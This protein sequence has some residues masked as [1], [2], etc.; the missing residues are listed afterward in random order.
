VYYSGLK[1]QQLL[2]AALSSATGNTATAIYN[3]GKS[4][5]YGF[6]VDGSVRF[7]SFFRVDGS[8]TYVNSELVRFDVPTVIP[9]FDVI[10]PSALTGDPLPSAPKWGLN[11]TAVFTLPVP[12]DIGTIE[13][14]ATY[15][16][17]SAYA[18]AASCTSNI[19]ATAVRQLDLNL[20]WRGILGAPFDFAVFGS[21]ITNQFTATTISPLFDSF[22]FDTRYL[23]HP[24][25]YGARARW[26]FG[27]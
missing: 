25:M 26:M 6:E 19:R 5:V 1:A 14:S 21:N 22:G 27:E 24:R 9:G 3:A 7:A 18:T 15:R 4:R 11:A 20:D 12:E 2:V 23:G 13:A 10:L 17:S 16:S 8:V